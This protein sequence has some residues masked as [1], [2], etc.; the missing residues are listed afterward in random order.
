MIDVLKNIGIG[1]SQKIYRHAIALALRAKGY[2]AEASVK[3]NVKFMGQ[4][5]GI[6]KVDVLLTDNELKIP[7]SV[8]PN[9]FTSH[10]EWLHRNIRTLG[11]DYGIFVRND[12]GSVVIIGKDH[13]Y[14]Y[15]SVHSENPL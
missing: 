4:R 8:A 7:I 10:V 11:A 2:N 14:T 5:I 13:T 15:L 3:I 9:L 6:A 12:C 1:H